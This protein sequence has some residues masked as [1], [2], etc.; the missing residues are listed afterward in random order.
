MKSYLYQRDFKSKNRTKWPKVSSG[1]LEFSGTLY[2]G[3]CATVGN[4]EF[5]SEFC[6]WSEPRDG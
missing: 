4:D 6:F 1:D 5:S 2:L 3:R